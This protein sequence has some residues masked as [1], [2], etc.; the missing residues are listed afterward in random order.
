M[1]NQMHVIGE[2]LSNAL[3]CVVL[4][5]IG[6]DCLLGLTV[7]KS[8]RKKINRRELLLKLFL[9]LS[10]SHELHKACRA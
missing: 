7:S 5:G 4:P 6:S 8:S 2:D 9:L 10:H 3:I 1:A